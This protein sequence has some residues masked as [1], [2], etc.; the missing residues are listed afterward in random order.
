LTV[1][2]HLQIEQFREISRMHGVA[3]LFARAVESDVAQRPA[4]Q[5]RIKPN[6][7]KSPVPA[8]RT[9]QV[10]PRLRSGRS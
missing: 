5:M 4:P 7:K 9:A 8:C 10:Q 6:K 1:G 2:R 3:H